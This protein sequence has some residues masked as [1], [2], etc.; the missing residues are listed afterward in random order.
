MSADLGLA[1]ILY[2][3]SILYLHN[4]NKELLLQHSNALP[5][6]ALAS[7]YASSLLMFG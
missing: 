3:V 5:V 7:Y 6:L 1:I 4:N 2:I